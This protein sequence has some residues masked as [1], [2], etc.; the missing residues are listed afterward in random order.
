MSRGHINNH[1]FFQSLFFPDMRVLFSSFFTYAHTMKTENLQNPGQLSS[2]PRWLVRFFSAATPKPPWRAQ[3][4]AKSYKFWL[5]G[6]FWAKHHALPPPRPSSP[7]GGGVYRADGDV[8]W[9]GLYGRGP[10][11][12]QGHSL[13][14]CD[15]QW[16]LPGMLPEVCRARRRGQWLPV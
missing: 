5:K 14:R 16:R 8:Q 7:R 11:P 3:Q 15:G 2:L 10:Q 1:I 9:R 12:A 13:V 6:G 4:P